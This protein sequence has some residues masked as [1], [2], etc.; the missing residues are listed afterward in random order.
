MSTKS[1]FEFVIS[2]CEFTKVI[3]QLK[4]GCA[5]FVLKLFGIQ[6]VLQLI[7]APYLMSKQ[8]FIVLLAPGLG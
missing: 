2:C 7:H 1:T 5:M 4:T 8:L 6:Q 3:L